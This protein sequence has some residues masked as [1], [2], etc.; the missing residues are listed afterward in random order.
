MKKV[1]EEKQM[2]T[3]ENKGK[4]RKMKEKERKRYKSK[5]EGTRLKVLKVAKEVSSSWKDEWWLK[6]IDE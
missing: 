4:Q 1:E 6:S 2:K 5:R 3:K